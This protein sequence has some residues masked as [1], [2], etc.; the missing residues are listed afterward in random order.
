MNHQELLDKYN[1]VADK[2][3]GKPNHLFRLSPGTYLFTVVGEDELFSISDNSYEV[4]GAP[5]WVV[6]EEKDNNVANTY[7]TLKEFKREW[8]N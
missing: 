6:R 8:F 5:D 3:K 4:G 1:K 7:P 2:A